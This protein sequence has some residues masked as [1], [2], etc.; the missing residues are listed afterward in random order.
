M[1]AEGFVIAENEASE[2]VTLEFSDGPYTLNRAM[3]AHLGGVDEVRS[4][5]SQAKSI[6]KDEFVERF[7]Q[8]VSNAAVND[9]ID[10]IVQQH[11]ANPLH[12][13]QQILDEDV[14]FINP[15][16]NSFFR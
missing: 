6:T 14:T 15:F 16:G 9:T 1:E 5:A 7:W 2:F 13:Q 8:L 3:V 12:T 4:Y 10:L 11:L